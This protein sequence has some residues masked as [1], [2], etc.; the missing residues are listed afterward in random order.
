MPFTSPFHL[1]S[2]LR[3]PLCYL[4]SWVIKKSHN[5]F[6]LSPEVISNTSFFW[7]STGLPIRANLTTEH[8]LRE[9][10]LCPD[11]SL[12]TLTSP[13]LPLWPGHFREASS[14][15]GR[16]LWKGK[17]GLPVIRGVHCGLH[18]R[19]AGCRAGCCT[20]CSSPG[21]GDSGSVIPSFSEHQGP[22]RAHGTEC[23]A[24]AP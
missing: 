24:P 16:L 7:W 3:C 23:H 8:F 21:G 17:Q 13:L 4:I 9:S 10:A 22:Q 19:S 20:G 12:A 5:L 14:V 6:S 15:G 18:D 11:E 1:Q 2:K